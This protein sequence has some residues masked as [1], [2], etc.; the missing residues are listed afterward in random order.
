MTH[1]E[2]WQLCL[3]HWLVSQSNLSSYD[4]MVGTINLEEDKLIVDHSFRDFS[5]S[6]LVRW[7]LFLS[8][9][10][11]RKTVVGGHERRKLFT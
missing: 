3:D 9:W 2:D 10:Q 4:K 11:V 6:Q 7:F 8:L 1:S 5:H